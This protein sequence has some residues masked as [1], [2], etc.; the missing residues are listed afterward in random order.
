MHAV[1]F[2]Q[3]ASTLHAGALIKTPRLR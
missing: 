2:R 3:G 1:A